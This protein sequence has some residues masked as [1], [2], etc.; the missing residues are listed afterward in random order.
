MKRHE[1]ESEIINK[2]VDIFTL[3]EKV[4]ELQKYQGMYFNKVKEINKIKQVIQENLELL[5]DQVKYN[6]Q[7]LL[8]ELF[9]IKYN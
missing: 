8:E 4:K 3:E 7:N 5:P 6:F 9:G 1:L 2:D